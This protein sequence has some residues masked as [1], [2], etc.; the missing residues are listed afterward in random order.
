MS[1]SEQERSGR[2][3]KGRETD[4]NNHSSSRKMTKRGEAAGK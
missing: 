3:M 2:K 4:K 1:R